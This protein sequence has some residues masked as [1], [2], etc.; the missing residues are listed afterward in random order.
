MKYLVGFV[1]ALLVCVGMR[2][3]DSYVVKF[4][5]SDFFIG[6]VSCIGFYSGIDFYVEYKNT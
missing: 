6:W 3:L 1:V 5:I 2:L 4:K